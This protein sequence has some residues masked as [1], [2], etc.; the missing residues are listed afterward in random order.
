[1]NSIN[2]FAKGRHMLILISLVLWSPAAWAKEG[3]RVLQ[4]STQRDTAAS[5]DAPYNFDDT[6]IAGFQRKNIAK[7][8]R[9]RGWEIS[10]RLY[11]GQAKVA[12]KWGLG[13]VYERGD[14][15]YGINH[16]RIQVIKRF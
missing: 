9:I 15:V 8:L 14:M 2:R 16:H 11:L 5:A 4:Y 1:M 10:D 6:R 12:G 7:D 3:D 13:V